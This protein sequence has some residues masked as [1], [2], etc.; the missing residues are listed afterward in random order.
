MTYFLDVAFIKVKFDYNSSMF[1]LL[2]VTE[3]YRCCTTTTTG[4]MY[5]LTLGSP[6]YGTILAALNY[7]TETQNPAELIAK[8]PFYLK[9]A[10]FKDKEN[11]PGTLKSCVHLQNLNIFSEVLFDCLKHVC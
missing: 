7:N 6:R 10:Q 4:S 9:S 5:P 1:I 8:F 2:K 3:F 11:I